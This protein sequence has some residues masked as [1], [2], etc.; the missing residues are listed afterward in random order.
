MDFDSGS[1]LITDYSST[2]SSLSFDS[3]TCKETLAKGDSSALADAVN[4]TKSESLYSELKKIM[5]KIQGYMSGNAKDERLSRVYDQ[6][7]YSYDFYGFK[8]EVNISTIEANLLSDNIIENAIS[9][10]IPDST[11]PAVAPPEY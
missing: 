1:T 5:N 4:S 10:I 6:N 3:P 2:Y 11:F 8:M 9:G 7:P